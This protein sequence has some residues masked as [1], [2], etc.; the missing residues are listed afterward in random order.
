MKVKTMIGDIHSFKQN[1]KFTHE[2]YL[3]EALAI[4]YE[5]YQ[6]LNSNDYQKRSGEKLENAITR[7]LVQKAQTFDQYGTHIQLYREVPKDDITTIEDIEPRIDIYVTANDYL[8]DNGIEIECKILQ[9]KKIISY[10]KPN[11]IN[12]FINNK[13]ANKISIGAMIG[14]NLSS[15]P[16]INVIDKVNVS[17]KKLYSNET[18]NLISK[19][20]LCTK[21]LPQYFSLHKRPSNSNIKI[22]HLI[23][24]YKVEDFL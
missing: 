14:Y 15:Y 23:L 18:I 5:A 7:H 9:D 6:K 20:P 19:T 24:D 10:I 8:K 12:S 17:L 11:G 1:I 16:M 2:D 4:L 21:N 13:Y 3:C 22:L